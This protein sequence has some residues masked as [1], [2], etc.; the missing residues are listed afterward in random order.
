M[1]YMEWYVLSTTAMLFWLHPEVFNFF[2]EL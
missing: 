2:Y 1:T